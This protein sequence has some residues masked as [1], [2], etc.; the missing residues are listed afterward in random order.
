MGWYDR[1]IAS[2]FPDYAVR[3]MRARKLQALFDAEKPSRTFNPK[4]ETRGPNASTSSAPKQIREVMREME[5]NSDV[6]NGALDILCTNVVG[7]GLVPEPMVLTRGG[8]PHEETNAFISAE[9]KRW[10]QEPEVTGLEDDASAQLLMA[11]TLFRDGAVL[12]QHISGNRRGLTHGT[13]IPYSYEMIEPDLL[14]D[15]PSAFRNRTDVF[16]GIQVNQWRRPVTYHLWKVHPGDLGHFARRL[17]D[18]DRK[19]VPA[20]N[21]SYIRWATRI[22]QLHGISKFHAVIRRLADIAEIDETERVAARVAASLAAFI[23][24]GDPGDYGDV[25]TNPEN[26]DPDEAGERHI[27]LRPG[28]VFDDLQPGESVETIDSKRPNNALIDFRAAQLRAGAGGIGISYSSWSKDYNGSYSAQRQELVEQHRLYTPLWA[29][30]VSRLELP[31]H[32]RFIEAL[33]LAGWVPPRDVDLTTLRNV[34]FTQ[35]ALPWIQ[36]LQEAKAY[37]SLLASGVESQSNVIR[38]RGQDPRDIRRQRTQENAQEQRQ[39]VRDP[40]EQ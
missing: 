11:R 36:P 4:A 14:V 30:F 25:A 20:R 22:N 35:P 9:R 6:I 15:D 16:G 27:Q 29:K 21:I 33:M 23:I 26:G 7:G 12:M 3:R 24:K 32:N 34:V 13:D 18:Q 19:Q 8:E 17:T 1:L 10:A 5:Q 2:T 39:V 38:S 37:E 40:A 28:M 31:K